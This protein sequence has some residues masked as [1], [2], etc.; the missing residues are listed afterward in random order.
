[1]ML[2]F[3]VIDNAIIDLIGKQDQIVFFRQLNNLHQ[4]GFRVYGTCGIVGVD[5]HD[6]LGF[7]SNFLTNVFDVRIPVGLL[8]TKVMNGSSPCQ[9]DGC[10][11]EGIVRC[12]HQ[13]F[14]AMIQ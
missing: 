2:V 9:V 3:L 6:S 8:I 5:D 12:G 11:P 1:M 13:N 4:Y 7:G 14:I 10:G